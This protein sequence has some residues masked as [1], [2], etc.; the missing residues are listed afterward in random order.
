MWSLCTETSE[1]FNMM[2][3]FHH[4]VYTHM[5]I[6]W[7]IIIL[8]YLSKYHTVIFFKYLHK[9]SDV[10]HIPEFDLVSKYAV[11]VNILCDIYL[12]T[13]GRTEGC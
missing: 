13:Y 2:A 4:N 11:C 9:I 5:Y 10:H 8:Q 6:K 1:F 3:F 12:A 7:I